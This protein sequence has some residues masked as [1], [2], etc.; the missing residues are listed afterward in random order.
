M[1]RINSFGI[2]IITGALLLTS[3]HSVMAAD[4]STKGDLLSILPVTMTPP[5]DSSKDHDT[6]V[7][8]FKTLIPILETTNEN[9]LPLLPKD[10]GKRLTPIS[11]DDFIGIST[12]FSSFH[13]GID[14]RAKLGTPIHSIM[15]GIVLQVGFEARG[16]GRY[17]VV[18][19]QQNGVTYRSLY[20][21]MRSTPVAEGD[22]VQ[23]GD[24]VGEVGMTGHTTGPH[25]HIELHT[26]DRAID[27]ISFLTNKNVKLMASK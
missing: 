23:A 27:P 10:S 21:H 25:L 15:T 7:T 24:V 4:L 6:D 5:S 17:V 22:I 12:Y 1:N 14:M 8:L 18:A 3:S 26:N 13:P 11:P 19:H 2:A 9:K 16:Y 20:A